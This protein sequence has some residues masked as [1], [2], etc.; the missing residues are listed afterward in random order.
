MRTLSSERLMQL[1]N[2]QC[3]QCTKFYY[4]RSTVVVHNCRSGTSARLLSRYCHWLLQS[5]P[6]QCHSHQTNN[7]TIFHQKCA[8]RH[9]SSLHW[10]KKSPT[11]RPPPLVPSS[12]SEGGP[13]NISRFETKHVSQISI[14][15]PISVCPFC[16]IICH[17]GIDSSIAARLNEK[18]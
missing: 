2:E 4:Y 6:P 7:A 12:P 13:S 18:V 8:M 1:C 3:A 15:L 10:C 5:L 9:H 16:C 11:R 17:G 14:C